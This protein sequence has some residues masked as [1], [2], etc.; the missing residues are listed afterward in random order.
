MIRILERVMSKSRVSSAA[1]SDLEKMMST[2]AWLE[3]SRNCFSYPTEGQIERRTDINTKTAISV[4]YDQ[5]VSIN[6]ERSCVAWTTGSR[7]IYSANHDKQ[8]YDSHGTK[9]IDYGFT[10]RAPVGLHQPCVSILLS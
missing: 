5:F 1:H 4:D 9:N 7:K 8:N 10:K 3:C 2:R 6:F